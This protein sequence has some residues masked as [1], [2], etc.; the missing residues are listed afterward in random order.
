MA[1]VVTLTFAGDSSKATKAFDEVGDAAKD[2][3]SSV[4]KS[5]DSFDAAA[6]RSDAL[7]TRAMGFRD[8]LTGI[9]DSA[10]GVKRAASGDWGFETL[11]L[12]GA[13]VGDFAS[14]L[15]NFLIP[16][17]K[18]TR[19]AQWALNSAFL[20]SPITWI[21]VGIVALIAI[22]VVLWVKFAGFRQFW[23]DTWNVI[24]RAASSAWQ[25]IRD[26]AMSTWNTLKKIPG[27][28]GKAFKTVADFVLFPFKTAFNGIAEAWNSTIGRLSWTVPDWVPIIGGNSISVPNLP[29]FHAGGRVPGAAGDYVPILAMAGE[30]VSATGASSSSDAGW[31]RVD[32]GE[33]GDALLQVIAAAVGRRGGRVTALGVHIVGGAV[34]P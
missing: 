16:A 29:T 13:G 33:V 22:F 19:I 12:L 31:L 34:R 15:T 7:D 10:A 11:L 4:K 2:M 9:Q 17:L 24:K 32:A 26:G 6:E 28:V 27:W 21:V 14:G 23:I 1:N 5:A 3:G 20:A 30:R 18:G 8:T 25:W